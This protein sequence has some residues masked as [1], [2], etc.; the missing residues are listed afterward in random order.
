MGVS[1]AY[2]SQVVRGGTIGDGFID[3][4]CSSFGF[5]FPDCPE[6]STD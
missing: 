4:M 3:K 6:V 5:K 2:Y 1:R